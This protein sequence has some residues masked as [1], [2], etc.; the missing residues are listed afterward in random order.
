MPTVSIKPPC[1]TTHTPNT[2]SVQV[3]FRQKVEREIRRYGVDMA[4]K[5]WHVICDYLQTEDWWPAVVRE[6][7]MV[8]DKAFDERN[9]RQIEE[10]NRRNPS[11]I[12]LTVNQQQGDWGTSNHF[13][14][15]SH[16]QVFNGNV[17]GQFMK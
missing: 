11:H 6:V 3:A 10:L 4:M 8:F 14:K 9:L 7:D 12:Q 1:Q 17:K 16:S 5:R 15:D 13:E 2:L